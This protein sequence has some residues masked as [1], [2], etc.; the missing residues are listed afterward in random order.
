M[1]EEEALLTR[2]KFIV[3]MYNSGVL[4]TDDAIEQ[5]LSEVDRYKSE[6]TQ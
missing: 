2:I 6:V 5:I 1:S 3:N 4:P